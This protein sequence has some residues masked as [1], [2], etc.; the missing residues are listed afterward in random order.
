MFYYHGVVTYIRDHFHIDGIQLSAISGGCS[1]ILA[2]AMGIDLYQILL[3]GLHMK[4]WVLK[5]GLYLNSV[6]KLVDKTAELFAEL[7][8]TEQD[9]E[10]LA[11]R[12]QCFI[13]VTQC[14]P[15]R[16]CC[17]G[18]PGGIR[19]LARL[20]T[21]SMSVLPFFRTPGEFRGKYYLDGGFS[22]VW[23]VP[24]EQPWSE[25]TRITCVPS[26]C[27]WLPPSMA[28][29][30]IQPSKF[31]PTEMLLLYPW[32]YQQQLIQRG[33]EDAKAS[34]DVL[35]ARGMRELPDAP[36]TPWRTWA[37]LF[38]SIDEDALP[39][40]SAKRSTAERSEVESRHDLILRTYSSTDLQDALKGPRLRRLGSKSSQSEVDLASGYVSSSPPGA[41]P[42]GASPSRR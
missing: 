5:E 4:Q 27:T 26:W 6:D 9:C 18:V 42:F 24:E 2:L 33:Y 11:A 35:K 22:A 32:A 8:M 12:R 16:H 1:T 7:G 14:F 36:L 19:E 25:V 40:L 10:Q 38:A 34:H 20:V 13:G 28:S 3:L 17:L 39:P 21:C 23:S 37:R 29:A 30:H 41:S 15:P 31:M